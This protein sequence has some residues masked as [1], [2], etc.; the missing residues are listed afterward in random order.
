MAVAKTHLGVGEGEASEAEQA[1]RCDR[2][3]QSSPVDAAATRKRPM[4]PAVYLNV[5]SVD[6]P[7]LILDYW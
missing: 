1:R 3:T 4:T 6:E 2:S 5:Q 7:A